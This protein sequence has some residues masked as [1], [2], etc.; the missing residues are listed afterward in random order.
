MDTMPVQATTPQSVRIAIACLWAS[1]ALVLLMI[2]A[3]WL[4]VGGLPRGLKVTVTNL[5]TFAFLGFVAA[6]IGS[7][8]RW[9]FWLFVVIYVVG[10]LFALIGLVLVPRLFSALPT[11]SKLSAITQFALQMVALVLLFTGTS[12]EWFHAQRIR[13]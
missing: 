9:A 3:S 4:G 2:A 7:G 11:L 6:G 12:K 1:A 10:S 8:R 5:L 13:R